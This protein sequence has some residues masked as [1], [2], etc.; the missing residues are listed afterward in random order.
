VFQVFRVGFIISTY[1]PD[2]YSAGGVFFGLFF[3]DVVLANIRKF[4]LGLPAGSDI[5]APD[6]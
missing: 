5:G 6:L 4:R 2:E 1:Q 3:L